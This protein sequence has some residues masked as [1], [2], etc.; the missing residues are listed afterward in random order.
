MEKIISIILLIVTYSTVNAQIT[1]NGTLSLSHNSSTVGDL[2]SLYG[3]RFNNTAMYGF[4]V[5]NSSL[6]YKSELK[7]FWYINSNHDNGTSAQMELNTSELNI[8]PNIK[9]SGTLS[10][11]ATQP[12]VGDIISLIGDRL[13]N[14]NMYGFGVESSSLYFKANGVYRWYIS[15]NH[16]NGTSAQMELNTSELN[17]KPNIK[18][19]GTLSLQAT[20]PSAGDIISLYGDRLGNSN[21]YGFGV[22]SSSLYFKANGVYR[23]YISTNADQGTSAIM[24]LDSD[25]L[26]ID[27]KIRSEEVKVEIINGPDYVF[28]PD[29][30]L[31]TLKET[32]EY[33]TENKH[34][35]EIPTA[36][37]MEANGVDIGNMNMLLLKKIE[38]LTLYQ[39]E[40]LERLE[41]AELKIQELEK[42]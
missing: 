27:G 36:K 18:S 37:E 10:L 7:H 29:Y 8:K 42:N 5:N 1:D 41:K 16:D 34:L 26:V 35:P 20:Q 11:Q 19:S 25:E 39:I 14:S 28:D 2:I 33:I 17:I 22:E 40:L 21:M 6:Y 32:K 9:S 15:S 13:G 3:N 30:K 4:G 38:E 31:R 12:S 24:K 23:W